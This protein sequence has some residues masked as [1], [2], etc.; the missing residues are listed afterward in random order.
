LYELSFE[1]GKWWQISEEQESIE[2]QQTTGEGKD[3]SHPGKRWDISKNHPPSW[4]L[5][6]FHIEKRKQPPV[7]P[8]PNQLNLSGEIS[9]I[10]YSLPAQTQ[11]R[12]ST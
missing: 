7:T 8:P 2:V 5:G 12:K 4:T 6:N 9:K 3:L 11:S 10:Q 1:K